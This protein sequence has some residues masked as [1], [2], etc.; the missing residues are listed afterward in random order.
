VLPALDP[1]S[2]IAALLIVMGI[3]LGGTLVLF[4]VRYFVFRRLRRWAASTTTHYD[5]LILSAVSTPSL[6]WC[7]AVPL[8]AAL[9]VSGM[10]TAVRE[11]VT[12]ALTVVVILSMTIV[13]ANVAGGL[14]TQLLKRQSPDGKVPG[15]GQAVIR[16]IV[17]LLGAMVVLN[18]LGVEITPLITALGVGGLA[19]ALALQDT[20]TNFFAGMHIL[21]E[22]PFHIGHFI[23]LED[24]HEGHVLDIGWRTTRVRNL[25]DD[26]IVVPNSKIAGSTI[27]NYHMPIPRSRVTLEVGVAY[28]SDPDKVRDVIVEEV[29]KA[30]VDLEYLLDTPE[31]HALLLRFGEYSLQFEVRFFVTD[32]ARKNAALDEMHRRILRRFRAE[33]IDIPYPVH[34]VLGNRDG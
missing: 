25:Q 10:D 34:T 12:R 7:L 1:S 29:K 3:F 33:G 27:L 31:P 2:D 22:R 32:I 9:H 15:L 19:V 18:A 20:L 21:L 13:A 5:D 26:V 14:V 28:D 30:T 11:V 16:A 23:Q 6:F 17:V 8:D 24:G 4:A